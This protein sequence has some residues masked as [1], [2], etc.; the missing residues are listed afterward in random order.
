MGTQSVSHDDTA[1]DYYGIGGLQNPNN[2]TTQGL[3]IL[4][5]ENE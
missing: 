5:V 4:E 1:P 2:V 3:M